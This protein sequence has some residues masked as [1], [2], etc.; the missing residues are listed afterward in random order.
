MKYLV[1]W[2]GY[3]RD[4]DN[5]WEP[6]HN[7]RCDEKLLQFRTKL[8]V[9]NC[10]NENFPQLSEVTENYDTKEFG[11][12]STSKIYNKMNG[13]QIICIMQQ[14]FPLRAL[15]LQAQQVPPS[16]FPRCMS[17]HYL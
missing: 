12:L 9:K 10:I 17:L 5:T 1:K 8:K 6:E 4:E 15:V 3:N 2:L 16:V 13:D 11:A 7:L 14:R